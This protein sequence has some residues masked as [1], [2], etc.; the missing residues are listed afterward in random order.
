MSGV[1][2]QKVINAPIEKVWAKFRPF[3]KELME[4]WPIYQW[5]EIQAPGK[6]EVGCVRHFLTKSGRTYLE[7]LLERDDEKKT[8]KY[9]LISISPGVPTMK[10]IITT[11]RLTAQGANQTLVDW[12]SEI[13][14]SSLILGQIKDVQEGVYRD[15]LVAL[16]RAFNPALGS[17]EIEIVNATGLRKKGLFAPNPYVV[18]D[19]DHTGPKSSHVKLHTFSP[20]WNDKIRLDVLSKEGRLHVGI[21]DKNLLEHDSFLGSAE[22]DIHRL[23]PGKLTFQKIKLQEVETGELTLSLLLKL[24]EGG[25]LGETDEEVETHHALQLNHV[26]NELQDAALHTLQDLSGEDPKRYAYAKYPRIQQYPDVDYENLPR[27]VDALHMSQILSPRKLGH[28]TTR[29]TE[30]FY[31]QINFLNR[32]EAAGADAFGVI[33]DKDKWV[34][35]PTYVLKHWTDDAEFCRQLLQGVNPTQITLCDQ[36]TKIPGGLKKL[37]AQGKSVDELIAEKRLFIL[38]YEELH[39]MPR[40]RDMVVYAPIAL[41]YN[42]NLGNGETRLNMLGF[43]LTRKFDGTDEVFTPQNDK[44]NRYKLAKFHLTCADNQYHQFIQHLGMAHL[45]M[46]PFAIAHHNCLEGGHPIGKVLK[47]HFHDTIGINYLARQTLVSPII[48]FTDRTFSLGTAG[49]LWLFLK[50][51]KKWTFNKMSFPSQLKARGFDENGSDGVKDYFY[52]DDGFKIWNFYGAYFADVVNAAYKD[53][54]AVLA[55]AAIQAWA[56]ELSDP[57]QG[58]IKEFPASIATKAQLADILTTIVF[59]CSAQHSAVNFSQYPYVSYVPNRPDSMFLPMPEERREVTPDEIQKALPSVMITQFQALFAYL[60]TTP[61]LH[62]LSELRSC[63]EAFPE[64]YEKHKANLKEISSAIKA[65]NAKL[66]AAGKMAYTFLDPDVLA[67]S[68]DI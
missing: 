15:A 8:F 25:Q 19:L 24:A 33:Y 14:A 66:E 7:K 10:G 67:S 16:E 65:R 35:P 30:Y 63:K 56:K 50:S 21:W 22:F 17:L 31:S 68:I 49:S 41:I 51:Y 45:A 39:G 44:P 2:V 43:Q 11:V 9:N 47:P 42:E 58:A 36:T 1:A 48:P 27:M 20:Q 4:W 60:L 6:D 62:P 55:D 52:R 29:L 26:L 28:V 40:Y 3:G 64:L 5:M 18:V 61:T 38:D 46:E 59:N 32:S 57:K 34:K 12:T 53:D 13:D 23:T 37:T 54:K